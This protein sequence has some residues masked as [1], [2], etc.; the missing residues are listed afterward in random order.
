M[1]DRRT[2]AGAIL[3]TALALAIAAVAAVLLA[4]PAHAT[5]TGDSPPSYGDWVINTA[6]KATDE[7]GIYIEGNIIINSKLTL[8]NSTVLIV[9]WTDGQ[10]MV[11]VTDT[12]ELVMEKGSTLTSFD[13]YYEYGFL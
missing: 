4:T 6:T 5:I 9:L 12:G 8:T 10:Y 13:S 11:N 2:I 1:T 7:P 3:V